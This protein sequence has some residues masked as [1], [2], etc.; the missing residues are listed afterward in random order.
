MST[1]LLVS[2][3]YLREAKDCTDPVSCYLL[4]HE[5]LGVVSK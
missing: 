5:D 4:V 1:L 2:M 3:V